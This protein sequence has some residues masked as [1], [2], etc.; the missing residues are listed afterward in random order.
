M[1]PEFIILVVILASGVQAFIRYGF[2]R[3]DPV[4][5]EIEYI[6]R[7]H[8]ADPFGPS[9]FLR[10]PAMAILARLVGRTHTEERFRN[11]L[12]FISLLTIGLV[13][14]AGFVAGGPMGACA[15]AFIF[16]LLPDRMVLSQ[17]IWP[18]TLLALWHSSIVLCLVWSLNV[19]PVSPW[20]YGVLAALIALTRIDGVVVLPALTLLAVI[21]NVEFMPMML[22]LWM[23][24]VIALT[25]M[26]MINARRYGIAL[27]DTTLLF[28]VSILAEEHVRRHDASSSV[29][30]ITRSIWMQWEERVHRDRIT[31]TR[32]AL[33][34]IVRQPTELIKG[35][36]IRIWQMLGPDTFGIQIILDP[37]SGAYREMT[38]ALRAMLIRGMRFCFPL[39]TAVAIA[40][41]MVSY[42]A[43]V[44]LVP[45]LTAFG[46]A[47]L[48][49]A[50]TRF[51]YAALPS[52][53]VAATA[54]ILGLINPVTRWIII[55][56]V[57]VTA[58]IL[59]CSPGRR[60]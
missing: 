56:T 20:I 10:V 44:C 40:G 35:I 25:I 34:T 19:S 24:T 51:R 49:H 47:C 21:L 14:S 53:S 60:E 59:L 12:A 18:D 13:G 43:R 58:I 32:R 2:G 36:A 31:A 37:A 4:G 29:E 26:T 3:R 30:N 5:D 50:R 9:P 57:I 39:L 46:V 7:A 11:A 27:P 33:V 16:V 8:A 52:L 48:F 23:P 55:P 6:N 15:A 45:G 41:A 17:H 38:P 1:H 22:G 54:G 28:N 42:T